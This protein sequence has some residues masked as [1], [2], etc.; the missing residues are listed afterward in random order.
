MPSSIDQDI[1]L[2]IK[3]KEKIIVHEIL[4][5]FLFPSKQLKF[6]QSIEDKCDKF[7][8]PLDSEESEKIINY[9]G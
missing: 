1:K 7:W 6:E 8:K 3:L 5:D 2:T 9:P 4:I